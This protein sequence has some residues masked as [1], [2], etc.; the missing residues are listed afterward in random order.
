MLLTKCVTIAFSLFLIGCSTGQTAFKAVCPSIIE[1]DKK[2][3]DRL[4][5]ETEKLPENSALLRVVLDYR[6]LRD[7]I[8]ACEKH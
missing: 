2:F 4:A 7:S 1:Y 3:L 5:N 6:Q 8:H